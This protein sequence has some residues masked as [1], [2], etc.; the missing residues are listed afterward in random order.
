[1]DVKGALTYADQHTTK[2]GGWP[3]DYALHALAAEVRRL[4]GV[5][6][7]QVGLVEATDNFA[8]SPRDECAREHTHLPCISCART[9]AAVEIQ[10]RMLAHTRRLIR[11]VLLAPMPWGPELVSALRTV[12]GVVPEPEPVPEGYVPNDTSLAANVTVNISGLF[13]R[14]LKPKGE[15]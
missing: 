8:L 14:S 4:Q 6:D 2:V 13:M 1:M 15:N 10:N 7:M 9:L 5:L 11:N 12:A 3:A